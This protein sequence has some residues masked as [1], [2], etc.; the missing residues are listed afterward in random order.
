MSREERLATLVAQLD[1]DE[2][3]AT[4]SRR[5]PGYVTPADAV[6][7]AEALADEFDDGCATRRE[8]A[9]AASMQLACT[10]GCHRCCT[11]VV[12]VYRPEVLRIVEWLRLAENR[13]AY[14]HFLAAYPAWR[15]QLGDSVDTLPQLFR[16]GKK[17]AFDRLHLDLWRKGALCAFNRDGLCSIYEVRP[18][19]CRNA[20]ALDTADRCVPDPPGGQPATAVSFVPLA[21]F[22]Q[23]ATRLLRAT[24]NAIGAQRHHQEALCS[25]VYRMLAPSP[26]P[27]K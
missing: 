3:Y 27:S 14:D 24:H 8:L 6:A 25:A 21:Q 11:I 17:A 20:H 22:L 2:R 16:D 4:G 13:A 1:A 23:R 18:L 12:L 19:G 26:P 7:V 15:Q 9:A 5:F 10:A